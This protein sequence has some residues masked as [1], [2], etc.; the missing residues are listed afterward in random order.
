MPIPNAL[1]AMI[2]DPTGGNNALSMYGAGMQQGTQN[3][4]AAMEERRYNALIEA[5]DRARAL[6]EQRLAY[7]HGLINPQPYGG[8]RGPVGGDGMP[9]TMRPQPPMP[10]QSSGRNVQIARSMLAMGNPDK[11]VEAYY[12]DDTAKPTDDMREYEFAR[13]QGY[14][15]SFQDFQLE[16]RKAGAASINLNQG[17]S[18]TALLYPM[19]VQANHALETLDRELLDP[20]GRI[21]ELVPGGK[22][23]Q[24]PEYQ[25]A[26]QARKQFLAA[27]LR[28]ESQAQVTRQEYE[29]YAPIFFP[30]PGEDEATVAQKRAA[31]QLWIDAL[32]FSMGPKE[33]ILEG[34]PSGGQTMQPRP[35]PPQGGGPNVPQAN[36]SGS[37]QPPV[38]GAQKAPDGNWYV[39]DPNRP[40][41]YLQVI[42]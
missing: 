30:E 6:E 12:A 40:G 19:A 9:R 21:A 17:E 10:Q 18:A 3:R 26:M 31:R 39:P 15:G 5:E 8:P 32:R 23:L 4:R 29:E 41:K 14:Q 13:S 42:P 36:A 22:Y 35:Q 27:V 28:K 20:R 33:Q 38:A 37:E 11:A 25:Q 1:L 2:A 34:A 16:M 24:T 7:A